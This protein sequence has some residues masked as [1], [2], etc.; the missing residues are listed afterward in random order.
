MEGIFIPITFFIVIGIV[1]Y[2]YLRARHEERMQIIDKGLQEEQLEY[3]LNAKKKSSD[4][5][6]TIK[7]GLLLISIGLAIFLGTTA[8]HHRQEE[9]TFGFIFLLPGISLL[10]YYVIASRHY[11]REREKSE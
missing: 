3:F 9:F 1:I 2:Y 6:V 7:Y 4:P 10:I 8:P 5:L 11:R